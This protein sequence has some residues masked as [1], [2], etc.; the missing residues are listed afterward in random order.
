MVLTD[1]SLSTPGYVYN[2]VTPWSTHTEKKEGG[3]TTGGNGKK[4][5]Y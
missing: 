1:I 3:H 2:T 5:K 4:N